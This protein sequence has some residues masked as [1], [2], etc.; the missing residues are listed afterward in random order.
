MSRRQAELRARA[1]LARM[2]RLT[3]TAPPARPSLR[4]SVARLLRAMA[5]RLEPAQAQT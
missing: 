3:S 4:M 5:D 1:E 2:A